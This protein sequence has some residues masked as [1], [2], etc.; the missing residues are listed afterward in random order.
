[1]DFP[2]FTRKAATDVSYIACAR[3]LLGM[4][5][6]IY[7]QFATHNA[8][9]VAAILE[10]A[11]QGQGDDFE[12]QRLHGM[13]EALHDIVLAAARDALPHLCAGGGASRPAGLS[14][15]P[16]AWRTAPTR[17]SSTRSSTR[18]VP[19]EVIAADPFAGAGED[20]IQNRASACRRDLFQPERGNS[21]GFDLQ[22]PATLELIE[23]RN[24]FRRHALDGRPAIAGRG[25]RKAAA[26]RTLNPADRS[27]MVGQVHEADKADVEAPLETAQDWVRQCPPVAERAA[28]LRRPPT[29]TRKTSASSSRCCARGRQDAARR[30]GEVREAVDFLRYYANEAERESRARRARRAASSSASAPG[31][32]RWRSSPARSPPRWPRAT[33]AGQTGRTDAADRHARGR[34]AARGRRAAACPATAARRRPTVGAALTSDPRIA[35]VCFTGSTETAQRINR[36]MAANARP[37]RR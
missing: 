4:T 5:D 24:R 12:F 27:D 8:H 26:S 28:V 32:S 21:K 33:R 3:K 11:G 13:G 6:R 17:A 30:V 7:P 20:P 29:S 25:P 34:A 19:P 23:A 2:V 9:T 36:A 16:A 14:R 1:M 22:D 18:N 15:A 37:T 35:G 10:M 31:T